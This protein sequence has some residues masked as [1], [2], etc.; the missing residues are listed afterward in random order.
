M[1]FNSI[2]EQFD[3]K[4]ISCGFSTSDIEESKVQAVLPYLFPIL[5]FL[6]LVSGKKGSEFNRFH[7]NQQLAWLI[8]CAV[9]DIVAGLVSGIFLIGALV[10]AVIG[11]AELAVAI[12]LMYGASQG[13]ALKIPFVSDLIKFF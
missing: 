7:A 5:F 13:M 10:R 11:I 4:S 9:L 6:P 12:S 1:D 2:L 8:V 3:D